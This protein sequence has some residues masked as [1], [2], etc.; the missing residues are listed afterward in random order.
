MPIYEFDCQDCGR[1]VEILVRGNE[2][3]VC[4]ECSSPSLEK[5]L[6]VPFAQTNAGNSLPIACNPSLPPCSPTCCRLPQS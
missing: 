5:R 1:Q 6:S 3:P 2:S 4:P